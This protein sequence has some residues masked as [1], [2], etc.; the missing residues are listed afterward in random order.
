MRDPDRWISGNGKPPGGLAPD[1]F[2]ALA[3]R[4]PMGGVRPCGP[5]SILLRADEVIE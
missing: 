2:N 4:C 1:G 5:P 3:I